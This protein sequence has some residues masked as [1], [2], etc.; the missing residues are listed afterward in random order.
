MRRAVDGLTN[1]R[2]DRPSTTSS[3]PSTVPE[4]NSAVENSVAGVLRSKTLAWFSGCPGIPSK[5]AAISTATRER[6]TFG[7]GHSSGKATLSRRLRILDAN[8]A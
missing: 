1:A 5:A 8:D 3:M 2:A 7:S 4:P 6:V